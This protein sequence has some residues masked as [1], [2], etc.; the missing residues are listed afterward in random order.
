MLQGSKTSCFRTSMGWEALRGN[1]FSNSPLYLLVDE[2]HFISLFSFLAAFLSTPI[3]L[4]IYL[5]ISLY[6]CICIYI[7]VWICVHR[8]LFAHTHI[9]T[10]N[11]HAHIYFWIKM[12]FPFFLWEQNLSQKCSKQRLIFS[13]SFILI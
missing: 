1:Y 12:T 7:Y 9:L 6:I 2:K 10:H 5:Y 11:W 13:S 3:Y 8:S 4:P